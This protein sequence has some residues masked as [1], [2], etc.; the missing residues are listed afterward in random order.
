[1]KPPCFGT[2]ALPEMQDFPLQTLARLGAGLLTL[3][4][5]MIA[6]AASGLMAARDGAAA[7][8]VL[9][10]AGRTAVPVVSLCA[11]SSVTRTG[12]PWMLRVV[13]STIQEGQALFRRLQDEKPGSI[14]RSV[15]LV[16]DDR[17]G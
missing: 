15:A 14:N 3:G 13:P 11:D 16:P 4:R 9:Q 17:A 7:H 10:I 8:L 6:P 5:F 2:S 12:V 1:M